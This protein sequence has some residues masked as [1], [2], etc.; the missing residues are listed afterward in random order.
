MQ[1]FLSIIVPVYNCKKYL[2]QCVESIKNQTFTNFEL[3]LVDDGSTDGCGEI[4]D[5]F[6]A[7]DY[8]IK[9]IHQ[10]N[11]GAWAA[12]NTGVRASSGQYVGF[13]DGDDTL[14]PDM[15]KIMALCAMEHDCDVVMC[16]IL[17]E[18]ESS[19]TV[20]SGAPAL[21]EGYYS[22]SDMET[23]VFPK[24]MYSGQF[25]DF[26]IVPMLWNK[27]FRRSIIVRHCQKNVPRIKISEDAACV[28]PSI[29]DCSCMYYL[30]SMALYRYRRHDSQTTVRYS[31]NL[32]EQISE[33][34]NL[35]QHSKIAEKYPEQLDYY[36]AYMTKISIS[37]EL[38]PENKIPYSEKLKTIRGIIKSSKERGIIGKISIKSMP[39]VHKIYFTLVRL[40]FVRCL[41]VLIRLT[42]KL[43]QH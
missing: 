15:Y 13:A 42:K 35:F 21:R 28:Y 1:P 37:N 26:G 30:K 3:I 41:A 17:S 31:E 16:D 6:A 11:G 27:I 39:L 40:G 33:L 10:P 32:P 12:R 20:M 2:R 38:N 9:A 34:Y 36:F 7:E 25:F 8:R 22:L 23:S 4:C 43:Q 14:E 5:S 24:M 19:E 29:T 18:S